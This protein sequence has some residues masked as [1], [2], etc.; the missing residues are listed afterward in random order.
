[1]YGA[2]KKR[3]ARQIVRRQSR[4]K[5]TAWCSLERPA[6]AVAEAESFDEAECDFE[7]IEFADGRISNSR[8]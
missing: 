7:L 4:P 6:N 3:F 5:E 1:M 8:S 2:G